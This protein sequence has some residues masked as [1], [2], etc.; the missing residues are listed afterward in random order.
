MDQLA[1]LVRDL[2]YHLSAVQLWD[3]DD[4]GILPTGP[5]PNLNTD[6]LLAQHNVEPGMVSVVCYYQ[7][8]L[9]LPAETCRCPGYLGHYPADIDTYWSLRCGGKPFRNTARIRNQRNPWGPW[10]STLP[11]FYA[12]PIV[13]ART[14]IDFVFHLGTGH[15]YEEDYE[16]GGRILGFDVPADQWE[17]EASAGER[18]G[19]P[20]FG[21]K[22]N[23]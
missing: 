3:E 19:R 13:A 15:H 8:Y 16:V 12:S 22:V 20:V 14:T 5:L 7:Q 11:C 2:G 18:G 4:P 9:W 10:G 21:R 6:Y 17:R 1:V 23:S